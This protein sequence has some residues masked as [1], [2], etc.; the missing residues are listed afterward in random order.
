MRSFQW[1]V[2]WSGV[3]VTGP[4]RGSLRSMADD[5]VA[6]GDLDVDDD[7]GCAWHPREDKPNARMENGDLPDLNAQELA[8][9]MMKPEEFPDAGEPRAAEDSNESDEDVV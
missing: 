5:V 9:H 2:V 1:K 4:L 8:E 7:P 3:S 6:L